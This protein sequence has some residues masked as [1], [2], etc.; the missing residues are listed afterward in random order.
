MALLSIGP[1]IFDLRWFSDTS[2]KSGSACCHQCVWR[3][4]L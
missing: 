2:H 3:V 1:E 4:F